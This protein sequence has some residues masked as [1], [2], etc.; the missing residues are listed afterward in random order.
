MTIC[1]VAENLC[2]VH[3]QKYE[4]YLKCSTSL[5]AWRT[6]NHQYFTNLLVM[7]YRK[8]NFI[9]CIFPTFPLLHL[10]PDPPYLLI[11]PSLDIREMKVK[12]TLGF[13]ITPVRMFK[14]NKA[15][16]NSSWWD[17]EKREHLFIAGGIE[18][19]YSQYGYQ[20]G[21]FSG[22]WEHIY[23]NIQLYYSQAYKLKN[24]T[25]F[26][27]DTCSSMFIDALFKIYIKWQP[28]RC[29]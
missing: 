8:K 1:F 19:L 24:C 9:Q 13:Q 18:N 17:V 28:A 27:T 29:K 16:D 15:N 12:T 10:L 26:Y 5:D 3:T 14:I 21:S 11:C 20:C 23:F 7:F 22:I 4:Q 6:E 25:L 2:M